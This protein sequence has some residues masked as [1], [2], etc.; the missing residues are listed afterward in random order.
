RNEAVSGVDCLGACIDCGLNHGLWAQIGFGRCFSE[1]NSLISKTHMGCI[2]I[3]S[4]IYS[5]RSDP[6]FMEG[7]CYSKRYFAA[8]G[9]QDFR[10]QV[11]F[12]HIRKRPN[13]GLS[14]GTRE[15]TSKAMPTMRRVSS[16]SIMPSSHSLAV[17]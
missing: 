11:H 4:R 10:K 14:I 9:D 16:G 13:C 12:Y 6:E 7:F 1:S 5:H 17:E 2:L 8:V 3:G 15:Q